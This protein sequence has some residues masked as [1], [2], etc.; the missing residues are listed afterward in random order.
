[1]LTHSLFKVDVFFDCRH[2]SATIFETI[3]QSVLTSASF[4]VYEVNFVALL[5]SE[6][7]DFTYAHA[8]KNIFF[9]YVL[10]CLLK[11]T[12]SVSHENEEKHFIKTLVQEKL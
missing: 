11:L 4:D 1:M 7:I 6:Y 8:F 10:S 3:A 12:A 5:L 2:S 9:D